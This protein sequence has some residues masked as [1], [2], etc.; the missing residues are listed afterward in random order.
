MG[1]THT[2]LQSDPIKHLSH[3]VTHGLHFF[4]I[5]AP[6]NAKHVKEFCVLSRHHHHQW[7]SS[8]DTG[9]MMLMMRMGEGR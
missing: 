4:H 5:L 1:F 3:G 8:Q 7:I 6:T 2:H 9:V